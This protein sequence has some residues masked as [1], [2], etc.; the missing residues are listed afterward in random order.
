MKYSSLDS[1]FSFCSRSDGSYDFSA[2]QLHFFFFPLNNQESTQHHA[3]IIQIVP[4]PLGDL[5]LL[6]L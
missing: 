6:W 5:H 2:N 1:G 3:I 4:V